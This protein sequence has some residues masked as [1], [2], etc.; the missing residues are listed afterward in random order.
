MKTNYTANNLNMK[1]SSD[2]IEQKSF[3]LTSDPDQIWTF[4][5]TRIFLQF[6]LFLA[7]PIRVLGVVNLLHSSCQQPVRH[8][9]R[10]VLDTVETDLDT[11][12][13]T[14]LG[15]LQLAVSCPQ[16]TAVSRNKN[17][18]SSSFH[19][20]KHSSNPIKIL[21]ILLGMRWR[22]GLLPAVLQQAWLIQLNAR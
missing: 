20:L 12:D 14:Q 19:F 13:W 8:G 15:S 7:V 1:F 22:R 18:L 11:I 10:A 6:P 16:L 4:E 9:T 2:I 3:I 21:S 17:T 5:P